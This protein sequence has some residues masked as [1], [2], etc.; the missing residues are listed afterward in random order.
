MLL[1]ATLCGGVRNGFLLGEAKQDD[2]PCQFCGKKHGDD[3]LFWECTFPPFF[4][5]EG[6]P[7]VCLSLDRSRA[8][9]STLAWLIAWSSQR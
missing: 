9:L 5:C 3:H 6:S 1:R 7:G 4:A 2:V 8:P